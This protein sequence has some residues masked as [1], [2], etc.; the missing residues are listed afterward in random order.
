MRK[1]ADFPNNGIE[2]FGSKSISAIF[3]YQIL[4]WE[5]Y[6]CGMNNVPQVLTIL[7]GK[8]LCFTEFSKKIHR[9]TR[10]AASD[11]FHIFTQWTNGA[12]TL[13]IYSTFYHNSCGNYN[14]IADTQCDRCVFYVNESIQICLILGETLLVKADF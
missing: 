5:N 13:E 7:T 6:I 14:F 4:A 2:S 9:N 10:F 12:V 11:V 1:E 8:N 3:Q